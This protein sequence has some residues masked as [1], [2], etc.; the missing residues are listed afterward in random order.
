MASSGE[1]PSLHK[2]QWIAATFV[3]MVALT[4]IKCSQNVAV[5]SLFMYLVSQQLSL[6]SISLHL[7]ENLL[8]KFCF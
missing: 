4:G 8:F 2:W 3:D 1:Q 6:S 7:L 5:L